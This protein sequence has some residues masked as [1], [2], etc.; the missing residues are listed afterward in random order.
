MHW[1][2]SCT[3]YILFVD[4]PEWSRRRR[5]ELCST[6]GYHNPPS[7]QSLASMDSQD[8]LWSLERASIVPPIHV[9]HQKMALKALAI[10]Y[11]ILQLWQAQQQVTECAVAEKNAIPALAP[12]SLSS[13]CAN[14]S[15]SATCA[16]HV[17]QSHLNVCRGRQLHASLPSL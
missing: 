10:S 12:E 7:L 17:L 2:F 5:Q 11:W 6:C 16:R 13:S 9:C 14:H 15:C 8:I 3:L 1:S 4:V